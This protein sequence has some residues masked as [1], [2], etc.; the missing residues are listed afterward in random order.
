MSLQ[1][2][3]IG[4]PP[5]D[6]SAVVNCAFWPA[7]VPAHFRASARL[8]G[9]VTTE[10]LV[11]ALSAGRDQVNRQMAD[12]QAAWISA[13]FVDHTHIPLEQWQAPEH[14]F[15]VYRNAVYGEAQAL[16]CERYPDLMQTQAGRDSTIASLPTADTHRRDSTRAI[17]MLLGRTNCTVDLI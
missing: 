11:E 14:V 1:A 10:R 6:P 4:T 17:M 8:D 2:T 3:G 16:L 12:A 13:G 7:L 15:K 5:A 9:T